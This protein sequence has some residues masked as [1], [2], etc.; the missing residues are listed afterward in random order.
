ML[1]LFLNLSMLLAGLVF[2]VLSARYMMDRVTVS[3]QAGAGKW[4]EISLAGDT[5]SGTY[6]AGHF[7]RRGQVPPPNGVRYFV[8]DTD[9]EGNLLRGDCV[10]SLEGSVP[11]SRWW[12]VSVDDGSTRKGLDAGQVVREGDGQINI[13]VSISPVP[14]NW[15][16]P[17]STGR[18]ELQLILQGVFGDPALKLPGVKRLWC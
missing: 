14:G 13:S 5:L 9:D 11:A 15:L 16:V 2:G 4:T 17:P 18:F 7:L 12:F 6:L 1:R 8:R 3:A 10:V